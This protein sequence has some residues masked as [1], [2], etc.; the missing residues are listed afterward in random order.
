MRKCEELERL[1]A[2]GAPEAAF[3]EHRRG[4]D[5]CAALADRISLLLREVAALNRPEPSAALATRL[6]AIPDRT[7]SCER[8]ADWMALAVDSEL[9]A[10]ESERLAFHLGRCPACREASASL[11]LLSDLARP[12]PVPGLLTRAAAA[13]PASKPRWL[14]W[15]SDPRSF[16]FAAYAAAVV[17]LVIGGNAEDLAR[18]SGALRLGDDIAGRTRQATAA[19]TDR[20][21]QE[22]ERIFR[23]VAVARGNLVGYSRAAVSTVGTVF[24]QLRTEVLNPADRDRRGAEASRPKAG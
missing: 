10:S 4:C 13:Q 2:S 8:A 16:A 23:A 11:G 19:L 20:L 22:E 5:E 7:V 12:E 24:E 18:R 9:S 3:E 1:F 15:I 14:R 21:G 6:S 17:L